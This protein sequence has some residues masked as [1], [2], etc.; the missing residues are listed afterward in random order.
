MNFA[1]TFKGEVTTL[2]IPY[3][4]KQKSKYRLSNFLSKSN[5]KGRKQF[6]SESS[7]ESHCIDTYLFQ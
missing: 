3:K 1:A 7:A 4:D 2:N 5:Y 6:R